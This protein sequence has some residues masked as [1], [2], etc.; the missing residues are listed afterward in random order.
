MRFPAKQRSHSRRLKFEQLENRWLLSG[1][2]SDPNIP[3]LVSPVGGVTVDTPA[4]TLQFKPLAGYSG[5][6]MVR[7]HDMQWNGQQAAGFKHDSTVHYLSILTTSNQ[8]TVPVRA[9]AEYQWWVHKPYFGAAATGFFV[10][11]T[12]VSSDIPV[13][14]SPSDGA[15]IN[16]SSVTLEFKPLPG[17][18]G[19]YLVRLHDSQW[20]GQQAAGFKHDSTAHYLSISTTATSVT[21]PVRP[22][23]EYTWWVHKPY[24]AAQ[25]S[26]FSV[27]GTSQSN[28][29]SPNIPALVSPLNEANVNTSTITLEFQP[30]PGYSGP[31][32]VR[33]HDVQWDGRQAA[34][35]KHDSTAHY[36]SIS[37]NSTRVTVPVRPGATYRWW[38]H[39]PY[40]AADVRT[41]ST[42]VEP[43]L[44]DGRY[45]A[46][47]LSNWSK[48]NIDVSQAIQH[49]IDVTP[50]GATLELPAG[51]YA[52]SRQIV[53]NR[54]ITLTS[55]GKSLN[56][57]GCVDGAG[58]C[59][60]LIASPLLNEPWGI[61]K[62]T[63]I[64][65]LHHIILDGNKD[66]REGSAA[67]QTVA[68]GNG[69]RYGMTAMLDCDN[70]QIV[71]NIF[72]DALGGTG[73]EV[74]QDHRNVLIQNNKFTNNGVHNR[75]NLW[76]DGLTIHGLADSQIIGNEFVDNTDIDLILGGS[77]NCLVQG[78]RIVHT[79]AVGTGSFAGLMI[80]KW[81]TRTADY[82]G[83]VISDNLI[84]GG[85]NRSVGT[86]IYLGSEGWYP[87]T[88][89]GW[90]GDSTARALVYN[91]VVRNTQNG[92]YV[93][94][95][96]FS[97]FDNQFT[98]SHGVRI[99]TTRG[100]LTS[101]S[102]IV[103]S[104]TSTDM[105]FRGEDQ[106]PATRGLFSY[107]T[108]IGAVPNWPF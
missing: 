8:V 92:M 42:T 81:P 45:R 102:P 38:V 99:V 77:Q 48:T 54:N 44:I 83:T 47:A 5:P 1:A 103:V 25:T 91:N 4:V 55:V 24:F 100:P 41:F 63:Q 37:T 98:N 69:N 6:Y 9:G 72:K 50:V 104:A 29:T 74:R 97:V 96:G 94:A 95:A 39:K 34:G 13:K 40:F 43:E 84:D 36:L 10:D 49:C 60:T 62:M 20:N 56:D 14:I 101:S 3:E 18:T 57:P 61:L 87:G 107:Q 28:P 11:K 27:E 78:N 35:F 67:F 65:A 2:G 51:E 30:L 93:A 52:I 80:H 89:L 46:T 58:D 82:T 64:Q 79:G 31:Y 33:L 75:R 22:G 7:L 15:K 86:G 19:P 23:A 66:G 17:Y 68:S 53:V 85:P 88:P 108:W 71:G 21:V 90:V 32:L 26:K 73:L 76:A 106:D 70:A 16:T 59:A 12:V 105:D